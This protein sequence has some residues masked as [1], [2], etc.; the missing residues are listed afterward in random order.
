MMRV[1]AWIP[2]ETIVIVIG[3]F[4]NPML[5]PHIDNQYWS[6][7]KSTKQYDIIYVLY[8]FVYNLFVIYHIYWNISTYR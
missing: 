1:I 5:S 6:Y 2:R 4:Y 8:C 3:V 7:T